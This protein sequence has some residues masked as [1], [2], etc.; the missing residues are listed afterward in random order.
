MPLHISSQGLEP[1]VNDPSTRQGELW[2]VPEPVP[3]GPAWDLQQRLA[4][5][6]SSDRRRD[7]LLLLQHHPVYTLGCTAKPAHFGGNE[8]VLRGTGAEL[9]HVNRG[10]SVTYHGPGQLVGYP[11]LRLADY[12]RGPREYV[13][14]LEEV[15][16]Q[17]LQRWDIDARRLEGRRGVWVGKCEERKIASIGVR[18]DR[19]VTLHGF[20]LNVAMDLAPFRRIIPCGIPGCLVTSM[21]EVRGIPVD[22]SSV[23]ATVA[24]VW[25][26]VFGMHWSGI[27]T[28]PIPQPDPPVETAAALQERVGGL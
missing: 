14:L 19:G 25:S 27:V 26:S 8:S 22:L 18:V 16:I 20:A 2:V 1:V 23:A 3:F 12:C 4:A 10:G 17:T 7:C 15:L 9:H 13:R 6:R 11:I 28:D 24:A 21:A 5:E